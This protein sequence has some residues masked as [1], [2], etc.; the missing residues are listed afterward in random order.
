LIRV[1]SED[2]KEGWQYVDIAISLE[3]AVDNAALSW[4]IGGNSSWL[5]QT[6]TY[7][8]GVAAAQSGAISHNQNSWIQTTVSGP[9]TLTFYWKV[10]SQAGY[11][12]LEFYIDG[13][14][15]DRISGGVDWQQKSY[16][17]SS[18]SHTLQWKYEKD[19]GVNNGSD[20][21]WLDKVEF[22]TAEAIFDT[23]PGTYPS[24]AGTHEGT[25]TP[26]RKITV[27]KMFTYP[28]PGTGG[29]SEYAVFY[30][31]GGRLIKK[32]YWNG[33]EE[34]WHNITFDPSFTLEAGTTYYYTI[35]TGSYPQIIHAKEFSAIAGGNITC[36]LFTDANGKQYYDWI[37]AV[38]LI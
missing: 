12:F 36:T 23:G 17:I 2:G 15:P 35:I 22:T 13:M 4:T 10:S 8:Y 14:R 21:G 7:Y 25:I 20:C 1:E 31:K 19:I 33:Y 30:D 3:K 29:H 24:I 26:N 18:G 27:Y 11:D 38:R 6:T 34:D 16:T 32:G 37:P 9:G 5:G 28:C